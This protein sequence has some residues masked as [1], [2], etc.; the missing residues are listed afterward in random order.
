M[1]L[2]RR[3]GDIHRNKIDI[4]FRPVVLATFINIISNAVEAISREGTITLGVKLTEIS[5]KS[6]VEVRVQDTGGGI[7]RR[8]LAKVFQLFFT[9]KEHGMGLG[10]W[11]DRV[12]IQG[13]GGEIEVDSEEGKG[14]TFYVRIP[15][16]VDQSG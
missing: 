4:N 13:L 7:P 8:D 11:R 3:A 12:V 10:L 1:L 2:Q 15:V 14:S 16:K 5:G 6:F 9:T